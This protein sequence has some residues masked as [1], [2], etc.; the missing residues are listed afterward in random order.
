MPTPHASWQYSAHRFA[1]FNNPAYLFSV[2]NTRQKVLERDGNVHAARFCAGCHDPV[3]LFSGRF[4]DPDFDDVN[5]PTAHAGI[6]CVACH[7]I[8][9]LNPDGDYGSSGLSVR[10]NAD[11]VVGEPERYPFA[12]SD[13]AVGTLDQRFPHQGEPGVA[14]AHILEAPAPEPG[15]LRHLPQGAP[16]R[17]VERLPLAARPEPL[18]RVPLEWR[19]GSRA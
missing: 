12:L 16:P 14:Q 19:L 4:D 6:G 17:G 9:A 3:P 8:Q 18:R 10:G 2:R 11:Y 13:N 1:S 7:A 15:V 5:D